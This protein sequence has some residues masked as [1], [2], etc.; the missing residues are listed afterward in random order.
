MNKIEVKNVS[1]D[2]GDFFI[3]D[4]EAKFVDMFQ[5]PPIKILASNKALMP[6]YDEKFCVLDSTPF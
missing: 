2:I 6:I 3:V 1:V 4:E 5:R